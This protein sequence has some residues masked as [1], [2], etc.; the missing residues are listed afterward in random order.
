MKNTIKAITLVAI[1]MISTTFSMAGER[2]RGVDLKSRDCKTNTQTE[3]IIVFGAK[4]GIIVFGI[5]GIIVFGRA[6]GII[7][8]GRGEQPATCSDRAGILVSD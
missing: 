5:T 6:E 2:T 1:L 8:F 4:D 3:G 7:V